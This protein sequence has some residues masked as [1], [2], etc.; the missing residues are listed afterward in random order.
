MSS[1]AVQTSHLQNPPAPP[2]PGVLWK[3]GIARQLT[4]NPTWDPFLPRLSPCFLT[5]LSPCAQERSL[6]SR[7]Y[8]RVPSMAKEQCWDFDLEE[9]T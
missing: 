3:E 9:L 7:T 1:T 5:P 6:A 2:P 4:P 8:Y